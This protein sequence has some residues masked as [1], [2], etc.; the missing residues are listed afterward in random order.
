[1][2][3]PPDEILSFCSTFHESGQSGLEIL[4]KTWTETFEVIQGYNQ[5]RLSV[6]ALSRVFEVGVDGIMVKGDEITEP[7][8]SGRIV[9]RSLRKKG[10]VSHYVVL[11]L[12]QWTS[13]PVKL[14]ILKLLIRELAN[15]TEGEEG[16]GSG[17]E[18]YG[19]GSVENGDGWESDDDDG[20]DWEDVTG[21]VGSEAGEED[22][23]LDVSED[24]LR[25]VNTKVCPID[26]IA[27]CRHL[28]LTS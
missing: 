6:V 16:N 14:K 1:V 23:G 21:E 2:I 11:I 26:E 24:V 25:G 12:V 19:H 20:N 28:L 10:I 13:V 22:T 3:H 18:E 15:I 8:N 5:I 4:L 17:G 9:T 27:D 7:S